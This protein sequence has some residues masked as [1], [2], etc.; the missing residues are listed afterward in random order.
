MTCTD[1]FIEENYLNEKLSNPIKTS[2][3]A[4]AK[5]RQTK[6]ME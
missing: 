2:A 1:I 3:I 5:I 6:L 4:S